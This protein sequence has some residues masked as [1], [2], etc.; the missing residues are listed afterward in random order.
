M[1][2]G[3]VTLLQMSGNYGRCMMKVEPAAGVIPV[4]F[5]TQFS[6]L[7]VTYPSMPLPVDSYGRRDHRRILPP[8][9][10]DCMLSS[11]KWSPPFPVCP[12]QLSPYRR[13]SVS[14]VR[15][16]CASSVEGYDEAAVPVELRTPAAHAENLAVGERH[17]RLSD[18]GGP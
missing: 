14:V 9:E 17:C 3:C 10:L 1:Q 5:T 18:Y 13:L 4:S 12:D 6:E 15:E 2:S 11:S 16:S 8:P 7:P